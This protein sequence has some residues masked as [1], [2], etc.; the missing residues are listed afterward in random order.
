MILRF[1]KIS[2]HLIKSSLLFVFFS[3]GLVTIPIVAHSE[4][5]LPTRWEASQVNDRTIGIVFH[6]EDIY[7][8]MIA[9]LSSELNENSNIRLVPVIGVNSVQSIYDSLYLK[10]IDLAIVHADVLEYL[11]RTGR[12]DRIRDRIRGLTK[13]YEEK[14]AIIAGEQYQSLEDL[15]G[16]DVNFGK[17]GKGSNIT[18]TIL[19]DLLGIDVNVQNLDKYDALEKV[20]SGEIAA[21]VYLVEGP[22]QEFESI[23]A[24]DNLNLLEIPQQ[25]ELTEL[26]QRDELT[27]A[28][29]PNLLSGSDTVPTIAVEV[30]IAS[31][32]WAETRKWRHGKL[33]QFVDAFV[34][35][36]D[37]LQN[38]NDTQPEWKQISL[39]EDVR[40]VTRLNLVDDAVAGL[41]AEKSRAAAA[42]Q[43]AIDTE[44][45]QQV[46][47][48]K[49]KVKTQVDETI[50][51]LD[52]P[53]K[54]NKLLEELSD[55]LEQ[56][57]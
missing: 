49:N 1:I 46:E 28:E 30:I 35:G 14:V 40:G 19:F 15:A 23:S 55:I 48:I 47:K 13:L 4:G 29:F 18:S 37:N 3:V 21:T 32:N 56:S 50:T 36:F 33:T 38:D 12:Y 5:E 24:N 22:N 39:L 31:Y 2:I 57:E 10:G 26:Y 53:E 11:E 17:E 9:D 7:R 43:L 54:L 45:L 27:I 52:D 25:Q 16:K 44:R 42:E 6:Y 20:K 8:R 51:Q 34:S 41:E